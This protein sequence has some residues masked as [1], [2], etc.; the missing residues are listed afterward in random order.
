ML[1][2]FLSGSNTLFVLI[3]LSCLGIDSAFCQTSTDKCD[4]LSTARPPLLLVQSRQGALRALSQL[5]HGPMS[6]QTLH[7][8]QLAPKLAEFSDHGP[9]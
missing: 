3:G 5:W 6:L 4:L 7:P 1:I 9:C 2:G 8:L